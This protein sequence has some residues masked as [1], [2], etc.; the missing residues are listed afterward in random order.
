M[1]TKLL[2]PLAAISAL[3]LAACD[4]T[5]APAT[6]EPTTGVEIEIQTDEN[7]V[8]VTIETEEPSATSDISETVE[9]IEQQAAETF[10]TIM[11]E[12]Q[13]AGDELVELGNNAMQSITQQ[14]QAAGEALGEQAD[15]AGDALN[16]QVDALIEGLENVRDENM[17]DEQKLQAVAGVRAA[18]EQAAR[19]LGRTEVEITA[20]GDNA[21]A[22][23]RTALGL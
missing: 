9:A 10:E 18:A 11:E 1:N 7:T 23:A 3:T 2:L 21:E 4:N 8:D 13:Q 5:P 15:A 19:L 22:R 17:S 14:M 20:T 16:Q 12:S 6:P